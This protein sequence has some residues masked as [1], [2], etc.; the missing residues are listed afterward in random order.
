MKRKKLD[1]II[2]VA[3]PVLVTVGWCSLVWD[4]PSASIENKDYRRADQLTVDKLDFFLETKEETT[5]TPVSASSTENY[6]AAAPT[7]M[8]TAGK[9]KKPRPVTAADTGPTDWHDDP[10]LD[11]ELIGSCGKRF[12]DCSDTHEACNSEKDC[13]NGY[14][15]CIE[16]RCERYEDY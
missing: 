15:S 3:L 13:C 16:E 7:S 5:N 9:E 6:Q 11:D 10:A 1:L 8:P 14:E 2:V 12:C 4:D